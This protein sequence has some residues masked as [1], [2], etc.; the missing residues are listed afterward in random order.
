MIINPRGTHGSGKSTIVRK[1][2]DQAI[3][4]KLLNTSPK[5][6][7]EGYELTLEGVNKPVFIV[8]SYHSACGGCDAIQPYDLIWPRVLK[9][10]RKGHV[11]FEGALVSSGVGNIGRALA[12]RKDSVVCFLDTPAEV[13]VA[14]I[15][16]RRDE[17]GDERPLN[18][19]NTLVK[20]KTCTAS[21]EKF[22]ELD[23]R[24]EMLN[25]KGQKALKR[26]LELLHE[27]S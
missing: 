16:K 4:Q 7:P 22:R 17:R 13:C 14:R 2:I 26:V 5:G 24:I 10:A 8:G 19:H 6:K 18:P 11:V 12:K 9:Y 3:Q 20:H 21:I 25:H 23:V 1:L 27:N 15:Q